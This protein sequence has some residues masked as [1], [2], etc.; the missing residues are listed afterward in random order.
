VD[1]DTARDE[2]ADRQACRRGPAGTRA[3]TSAFPRAK[4]RGVL[5]IIATTPADARTSDDELQTTG[6][7]ASRVPIVPPFGGHG[8]AGSLTRVRHE[9]RPETAAWSGR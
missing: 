3:W 5:G 2:R 9:A 8:V 6:S 7:P 4:L 1:R